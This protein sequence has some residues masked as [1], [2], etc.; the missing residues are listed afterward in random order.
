MRI[1]PDPV[2][3]QWDEGNKDKSLIKHN[4]QNTEIEE[5]FYDEKKKIFKDVVHSAQEKRYRVIG[6]TKT[7]RLL[8]IV[9]TIR[10]QYVRVISGRD[11]NKKEVYLYEK[12]A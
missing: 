11:V 4:V 3:F 10:D 12:T 7:E 6:R 5:T 9:F 8:F 1:L 2:L